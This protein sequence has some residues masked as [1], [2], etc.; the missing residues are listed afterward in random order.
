MWKHDDGQKDHVQ[1][2]R[3]KTCNVGRAPQD[4]WDVGAGGNVGK[5]NRGQITKRLHTVLRVWILS[6]SWIFS[7]R[8]QEPWKAFR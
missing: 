7:N 1:S 8:V 5:V 3:H 2:M 6:K 4:T